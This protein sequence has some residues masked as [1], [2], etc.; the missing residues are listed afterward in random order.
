MY[1]VIIALDPPPNIQSGLEWA[2]KI[3]GETIDL[4]PGYKIGL[5]L[6]LKTQFIEKLTASISVEKKLVIADFKLADI[7]DVMLL[8][9]QELAEKGFNAFIVHGFIG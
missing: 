8:A 6:L 1:P 5:P 9:I 7:G 3:V 4:V 2:L